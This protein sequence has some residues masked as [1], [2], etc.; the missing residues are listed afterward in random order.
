MENRKIFEIEIK[1]H[2]WLV[3]C[4]FRLNTQISLAF[5]CASNLSVLPSKFQLPS[6]NVLKTNKN[7]NEG[8]PKKNELKILEKFP[9][10]ISHECGSIKFHFISIIQIIHI[11]SLPFSGWDDLYS[12]FYCYCWGILHAFFLFSKSHDNMTL[13]LW[14]NK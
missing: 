1:Y 9:L 7:F 14:M 11:F 6:R 10:H 13:S 5:I 4:K 8:I 3:D 12:V 2:N